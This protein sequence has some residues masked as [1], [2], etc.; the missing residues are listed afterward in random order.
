MKANPRPVESTPVGEPRPRLLMNGDDTR[1]ALGGI[2]ESQLRR[3]ELKGLLKPVRL[4]RSLRSTKYYLP[5]NVAEVA[6]GQD[7]SDLDPADVK[8][9]PRR[10]SSRKSEPRARR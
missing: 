5:E 4:I 6:R 9:P 2:S 7:C 3:L 1:H 10:T 8:L